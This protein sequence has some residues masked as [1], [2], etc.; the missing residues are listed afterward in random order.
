MI[1]RGVEGGPL[2]QELVDLVE[3]FADRTR[4]RE[5]KWR[6]RHRPPGPHQDRV[7]QQPTEPQ[8]RGAHGRLADVHPVRGSRDAAFGHQCIECDQQVDVDVREVHEAIVDRPG[9]AGRPSIRVA[10][11]KGDPRAVL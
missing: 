3:G 10:S 5:G 2:G 4:Q 9:R 8:E 11:E 1:P 6:R 7:V